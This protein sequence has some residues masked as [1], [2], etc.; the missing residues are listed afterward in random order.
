MNSPYTPSH[1]Q[2]THTTYDG[3]NVV[4]SLVSTRVSFHYNSVE[5]KMIKLE[6]EVPLFMFNYYYI[7][8]VLLWISDMRTWMFVY[9]SVCACACACECVGV[10]VTIV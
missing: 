8:N 4:A 2:Y 7:T 6:N 5:E 1:D 3:Y 10:Y 9:L